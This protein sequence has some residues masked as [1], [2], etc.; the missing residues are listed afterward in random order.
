MRLLF[1][2]ILIFLESG[3][4]A[5]Q[6]LV[7]A[8]KALL[9]MGCN[10]ELV[11]S[12]DQDSTAW[13]AINAGIKEITRIE[14]L[15]SSWDPQSQT[16]E[17]NRMAGIRAVKVDK[18]LYDLIYRSKKISVLTDGAFDIS[19][20]S[21]DK[22]WQFDRKE[23]E[24][25]DSNIVQASRRRI[26]YSKI[27]LNPKDT[28]VFLGEGMKIGFGAIGKGYAANMAKQVMSLI[29][30]VKGGVVNASGDLLT[31]GESA[32]GD[33]WKISIS[34]P[35]NIKQPIAWLQ[36]DDMSVVTSG[37][38]EKYF[39]S[40]GMRYAHIINPKTGYPT[41]GIT[42]VT[43]ICPDAELA[44]ALAT[45]VFVMGVEKGMALVDQLNQVECIIIDNSGSLHQS[46]N[47]KLNYY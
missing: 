2:G 16:S 44:D 10:F 32:T 12:A 43:I 34:K 11:A 8:K 41:T 1:I 4:L 13:E 30:G 29:S 26:D 22:V 46:K 38:Y 21:M 27:I 40:G 24:L 19:F 47:L 36:A 3:G 33:G 17:I 5:A 14:A 39:T 15:I 18:E 25:P 37:D 20:A 23:Q 9:L 45:S 7:T 28:T 42:S 31:W 6:P 35:D